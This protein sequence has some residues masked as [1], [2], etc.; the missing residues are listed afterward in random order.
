VLSVLL[1][2]LVV[3]VPHVC[4]ALTVQSTG[5]AS[6]LHGFAASV[7]GHVAPVPTVGLSRPRVRYDVPPSHV[8]EHAAQLDHASTMQLT[9]GTVGEDVGAG[10]AGGK[11]VGVGKRD[12][13][14]VDGAAVDG[15]TVDGVAVDGIAVAGVP[16]TCISKIEYP[17]P[18]PRLRP[19]IRTNCARRPTI[20]VVFIQAACS[21]IVSAV[22]HGEVVPLSTFS[23]M[24][25]TDAKAA[26]QLI[27]TCEI[28]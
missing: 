22:I 1:P 3:H 17:Y 21:V 11:G 13:I 27:A 15:S 20:A 28:S 14:A 9:A 19:F 8:T 2:Q 7:S 12:G 4:H 18:V 10:D 24:S 16:L 23:W 25:Y 6:V 5:H 26:S